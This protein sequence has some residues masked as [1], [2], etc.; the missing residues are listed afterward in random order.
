MI[1]DNLALT[2][3][4]EIT[5]NNKV[6]QKTKNTVVNVGKGWVAGMMQGTGSVMSHMALGTG[7]SGS[8]AAGDTGLGGTGSAELANSRQAFSTSTSMMRLHVR[9]LILI[10]G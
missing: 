2:G 4:L 7:T 9:L 6:V 3:A 1:K 8:A 5:L 10:L